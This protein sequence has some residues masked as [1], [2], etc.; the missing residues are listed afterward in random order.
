MDVE[1]CAHPLVKKTHDHHHQP[2]NVGVKVEQY[3]K[4][5]AMDHNHSVSAARLSKEK[6]DLII[7]ST[8]SVNLRYAYKI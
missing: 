7:E 1:N 8:D 6:I 4:D 2:R 3:I 5:T